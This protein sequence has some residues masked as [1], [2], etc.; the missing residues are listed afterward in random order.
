M[1]GEHEGDVVG[2]SENEAGHLKCSRRPALSR[3]AHGLRQFQIRRTGADHE[4]HAQCRPAEQSEHHRKNADHCSADD[5]GLHTFSPISRL[6][7][8]AV[9]DRYPLNFS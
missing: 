1:I 7:G 4:Q 5:S 6:S 9:P 8:T 2:D 3:K